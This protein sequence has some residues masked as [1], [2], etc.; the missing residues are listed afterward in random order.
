MKRCNFSYQDHYQFLKNAD[1]PID[2]KKLKQAILAVE[3]EGERT[4]QRILISSLS[5]ASVECQVTDHEDITI[6]HHNILNYLRYERVDLDGA[7]KSTL[8]SKQESVRLEVVIKPRKVYP[9]QQ[10]LTRIRIIRTGIELENETI[11]PLETAGAH[12]EKINQAT[13]KTVEDGKNC[14]LYTSA[15]ADE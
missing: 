7:V 10:V 9:Q 13:Y 3:L 15:A 12:V 11:T 4:E 6:M 5:K 14:L 1:L 2:Y 8:K